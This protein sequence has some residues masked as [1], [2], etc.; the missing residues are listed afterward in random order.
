[1]PKSLLFAKGI[2]GQVEL[3]T[4]RVIIHRKGLLNAFTHGLNASHEIPLA[5]LSGVDFRQ[6]HILKQGMIDFD[7]SGKQH[8]GPKHKSK[9]AVLFNAKQEPEFRKIKEEIFKIIESNRRHGTQP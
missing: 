3:M 9:N 8:Y 1:M 4:D 7:H 6:A 2:D 5:S